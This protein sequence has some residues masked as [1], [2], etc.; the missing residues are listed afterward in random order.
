MSYYRNFP[1][2]FFLATMYLA[3]F[4]V[5]QKVTFSQTNQDIL[6]IQG[7]IQSQ[8]KAMVTK[9]L[10][11]EPKNEDSSDALAVAISAQHI[12]YKDLQP[13]YDCYQLA[14]ADPAQRHGGECAIYLWLAALN[15]RFWKFT[16]LEISHSTGIKKK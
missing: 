4:T 13:G 15:L 11:I 10:G 3:A 7:V 12:G 9:L 6:I 1:W 5:P 8:I 2:C 16:N 14:S